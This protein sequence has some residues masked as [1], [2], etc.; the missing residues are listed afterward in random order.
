MKGLLLLVMLSCGLAITGCDQTTPVN[1]DPETVHARWIEA[2]RT[3]DLQG[4]RALMAPME[5]ADTYVA[6]KVSYMRDMIEHQSNGVV[7]LGPLR[8]V[9]VLPL[10]DVGQGKVGIS[11]WRFAHHTW[12]YETQLAAFD[13]AWRITGWGGIQSCP[14]PPPTT[15]GRHA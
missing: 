13:G 9:D 8:G 3:N 1:P 7:D 15:D 2:L 11:V 10:R 14:A 12:C 4:A 5:G 6:Q